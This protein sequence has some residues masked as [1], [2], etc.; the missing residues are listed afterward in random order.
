MLR[1]PPRGYSIDQLHAYA[2]AHGFHEEAEVLHR[3]L[4]LRQQAARRSTFRRLGTVLAPLRTARRTMFGPQS[5]RT[6]LGWRL[7]RSGPR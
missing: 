1:Q 5:V 4:T 2:R 6:Q 3:Y 7:R